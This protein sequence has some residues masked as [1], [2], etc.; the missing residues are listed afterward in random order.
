MTELG[1]VVQAE[2]SVEITIKIPRHLLDELRR[3]DHDVSWTIRRA[4]AVL[5]FEEQRQA[6]ALAAQKRRLPGRPRAA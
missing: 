3:Y 6:E 4:L 5:V 2:E 1:E